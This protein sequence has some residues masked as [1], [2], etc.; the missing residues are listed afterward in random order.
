[1]CKDVFTLIVYRQFRIANI[2]RIL[3]LLKGSEKIT[4]NK[5]NS[6]D[7]RFLY[8]SD[9]QFESDYHTPACLID[10]ENQVSLG[11]RKG[12]MPSKLN[13]ST[14]D[15]NCEGAHFSKDYR[16]LPLLISTTTKR[17]ISPNQ[18]ILATIPIGSS[19]QENQ[20]FKNC[21]LEVVH[22]NYLNEFVIRFSTHQL[23]VFVK[24]ASEDNRIR[25][26]LLGQI[27]TFLSPSTLK[28]LS[29]LTE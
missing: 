15:Y 8:R 5:N 10:R 20:Y 16:G 13:H 11:I 4:R 26:I 9:R 17:L 21:L 27:I 3:M 7:D 12:A 22:I 19:I 14:Y 29:P 6:D 28:Y 1:M 24:L 18:P 25:Q 2:N 23:T